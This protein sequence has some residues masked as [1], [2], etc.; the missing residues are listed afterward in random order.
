[1]SKKNIQLLL[2]LTMALLSQDE[3][4]DMDLNLEPE[5]PLD[6]EPVIDVE[7]MYSEIKL[8]RHERRKQK[9]LARKK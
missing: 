9:A 3:H 7:Q 5:E 1:M 6:I 2:S 8:N 4:P